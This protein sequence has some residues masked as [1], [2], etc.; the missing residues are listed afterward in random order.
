MATDVSKILIVSLLWQA[1]M[2]VMGNFFDTGL[3]N[4]FQRPNSPAD[5]TGLLDH[6][7]HWDA[8]WY[9]TALNGAY[10]D[11]SSPVSVFYP[12]FPFSVWLVQ[13]LS[14]GLLSMLEA[15]LLINTAATFF[16]LLALTKIGE[17]LLGRDRRW[18]LPA[19]F[20]TSPAAIFLHFFYTEALFCAFAFWSYLFALRRQWWQMALA[21]A[22]LTA[23]RLPAVLFIALCGLEYLRAYQWRPR[24]FLNRNLLWFLLTPAGFLGFASYLYVVRGDFLAM[25]HG[26]DLT[27]DWVYQVFNP[28][29]F[30]LY[31]FTLRHLY[32]VFTTPVPFDEGQAVNFLLPLLGIFVLVAS[33]L[34]VVS[35]KRQAG[36]P[37]LALGLLGAVMFSLNSNLVSVHRYL[38]PCIVIYIAIAHL[39]SRRDW[40]RPLF[41]GAIY[42]GIML[43]AFLYILFVN[44]YFAG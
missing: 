41:L 3:N 6:M 5:A 24:R 44:G 21:L 23:I 27:D 38:L 4:I 18:W 40:L 39:A 12:L 19:L 1:L 28:N 43:Q 14:L 35:L 31:D 11:P 33:S 17:I 13:T 10:A 8:G 29:I 42:L 26:Y 20:I 25:F 22:A 9:Q 37:L 16:S 7:F 36:W 34:Y 32:G 2:T 30:A 15:G